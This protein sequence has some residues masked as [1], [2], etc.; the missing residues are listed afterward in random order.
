VPPGFRTDLL[1]WQHLIS[2]PWLAALIGDEPVV[3]APLA[4]WRLL[5][6]GCD[7]LEA[8]LQ[9]HIPGARYVDSHQLEQLPFWNKVPDAALR[10]LLDAEGIG[11]QTC[12]VVVGR[13]ALAAARMAHL[14]LV[15]G[16]QDVRLLDGN[17][18]AWQQAGLTLQQGPVPPPG[19][20]AGLSL[21]P[22]SFPLRPDYLV[23]TEQVRALLKQSDSKVVSIR[24]RAEFMGETSGYD[25]IAARGEIAGA[26][27]G[28]AGRDGDAHSM[29]AYQTDDG[30][31]RPAAELEA[32][33][34]GAGLDQFM[35]IAFYCG[36]G[37]RAS[38]AF[39]YAWLMGWER[40][41]VYDGGWFEWSSDPANSVICRM[42]APRETPSRLLSNPVTQTRP[43]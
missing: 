5:E 9:G 34:A 7:Q 27:W 17:F 32:L 23:D 21:W 14:L 29:S 1:R 33:W 12:V 40:I 15:A 30:R 3:A 39:F 10:S 8:Y 2:A 31:M 20:S 18:A 41:S 37:W 25:Y 24:T 19:P 35:R 26:V 28:R 16:V 13:N 43:T 22:D 6:L 11:P 38:L 4:G 42:A 36:T